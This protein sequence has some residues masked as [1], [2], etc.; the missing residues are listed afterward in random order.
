MH[1]FNVHLRSP[2]IA[3]IVWEYAK[4]KL[5]WDLHT[6]SEV[7]L[8]VENMTNLICVLRPWGENLVQD[9]SGRSPVSISHLSKLLRQEPID[10]SQ[11]L[12]AFLGKIAHYQTKRVT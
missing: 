3:K 6:M 1:A 2:K 11:L 4:V 12:R 9:L 7:H 5:V 10:F 8:G